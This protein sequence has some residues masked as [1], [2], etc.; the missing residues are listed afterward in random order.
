MIQEYAVQTGSHCVVSTSI[1]SCGVKQA[2]DECSQ[3]LKP[4]KKKKKEIDARYRILYDE[5]CMLPTL[6]C[7]AQ[8]KMFHYCLN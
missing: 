7:T 2:N 3:F 6:M 1:I 4:K 5:F 8:T